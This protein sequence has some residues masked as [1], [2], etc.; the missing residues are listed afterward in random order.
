MTID[1]FRAELEAVMSKNSYDNAH[2]MMC[3]KKKATARKENGQ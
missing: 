2:K 3:I 1:D